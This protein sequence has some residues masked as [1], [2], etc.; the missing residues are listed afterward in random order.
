M[1]YLQKRL[2]QSSI[3]SADIRGISTE[4]IK[5]E[6][7]LQK[8]PFFNLLALHVVLLNKPR[9]TQLKRACVRAIE[10][11]A[12][13]QDIQNGNKL[14]QLKLKPLDPFDWYRSSLP[15]ASC[16]RASKLSSCVTQDC[17][18]AH[19]NTASTSSFASCSLSGTL[20]AM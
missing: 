18:E 16:N 13:K 10:I 9:E 3:S 6:D 2:K 8:A 20:S 11:Q 19:S 14:N 4:N 15:L 1:P 12:E 7:Q 5:R 17:F